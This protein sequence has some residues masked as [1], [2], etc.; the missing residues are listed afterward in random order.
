MKRLILMRHAKSDWTGGGS[1]DHDRPLNARGRSGAQALGDWMRGPGLGPDEVLC[2]SAA[3]TR[4]TLD[5]LALSDAGVSYRND[6]YLASPDQIL[7]VLRAAQGNTVL[8]LGHNPGV[9]IAAEQFATQAPDHPRFVQYPT[10]ATLVVDFDLSD[11]GNVDWGGG[12]V[13]MFVTP[14]DLPL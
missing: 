9:G 13:A 5:L 4:E 6:L 2:S 7:K 3:R 8:M 14:H 12:Q 10:G 11:W 1:S